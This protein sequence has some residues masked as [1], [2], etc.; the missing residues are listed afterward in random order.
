MNAEAALRRGDR[1]AVA[2]EMHTLKG[3]AATLGA[4][5]L[6]Q[7]AAETE[8]AFK[9]APGDNDGRLIVALGASVEVAATVLRAAA[10]EIDP[11]DAANADAADPERILEHL[12]ELDGLL[13]EHNMR[14]LDVFAT[15]RREAAGTLAESLA[16]LDEALLK[17]DFAAAREKA[18]NLK[19]IL[20]S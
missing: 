5:A 4:Q 2:S 8:A 14:A 15:L 11:P 12:D 7:Q 9:A 10:E 19:A 17:F 18:A 1:M 6:R 13:A 3:L 20:T 16:P